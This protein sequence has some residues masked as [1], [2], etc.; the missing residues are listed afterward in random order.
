MGHSL[1]SSNCY[2]WDKSKQVET[3]VDTL[4][5]SCVMIAYTRRGGCDLRWADHKYLTMWSDQARRGEVKVLIS[6]NYSKLQFE[7]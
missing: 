4:S 7:G 1:I 2:I 3:P 6:N 5:P